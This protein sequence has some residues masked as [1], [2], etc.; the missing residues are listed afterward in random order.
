[1]INARFAPLMKTQNN[2]LILDATWFNATAITGV[3]V[4]EDI[5]TKEI[6]CYIDGVNSQNENTEI[7]D[8]Q[9]VIMHGAHFPIEAAKILFPNLDFEE[10]WVE[11]HPEY[12]L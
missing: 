5:R 6:K 7:K 10:S 8:A 2:L 4:C 9:K 3:V 1:M 12:F 11:N